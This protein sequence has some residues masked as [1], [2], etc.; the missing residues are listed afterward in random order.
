M[1]TPR[2]PYEILG[3]SRT[4]SPDDIKKAYRR[5]AKQYHPDRNPN[6]PS[7]ADRFK[8]VQ[9]A[10][11]VLGDAARRAQFDRYGAGGPA[12]NIDDWVSQSTVFNRE[13][14][15]F[16]A[17]D[18]ASIFEQF[19]GRSA[20]SPARSGRSSRRAARDAPPPEPIEHELRLSFDDAYRG[21][22]REV[23]L[24]DGRDEERLVVTI[25]AG[26]AEGQ[27]IRVRGRGNV[28]RSGRG[29]LII[30]CRVEPHPVFRRD[31]ADLL[32]DLPVSFPQAAL[33]AVVDAPTPDGAARLKV[34]PGT[35]SGTR[36]RLRGRGMPD[37]RTGAAGDLYAVVK[38]LTPARLSP[39]ATRLIERLA[40][41]LGA[42]EPTAARK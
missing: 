14:G 38:I 20:R 10:Y 2:D 19:F 36:L 24:S 12:P 42:P 34:P 16:H 25:P 27:K 33:G 40:E 7:A 8:Q 35:S 23:V 5:L 21:V 18:L 13:H 6:D 15:G 22:R 30:I 31:G 9:A 29:D 11:E 41:E 4:A 28:G 3:V 1:K 26:V 39:E 32:F 17:D 37:A